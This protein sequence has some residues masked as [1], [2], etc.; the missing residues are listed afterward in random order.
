MIGDRTGMGMLSVE[1]V[2]WEGLVL[3]Y[4]IHWLRLSWGSGRWGHGVITGSRWLCPFFDV[5]NDP[6]PL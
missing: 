1:M 3:G 2:W 5:S 6:I 4:I